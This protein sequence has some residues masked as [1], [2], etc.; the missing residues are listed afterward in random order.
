MDINMRLN[1][2]SPATRGFSLV[3]LSMVIAIIGISLSGALDLATTSTTA[4]MISSTNA[5]LDAVEQALQVFVLNNQR[6]PCPADATASQISA[7]FEGAATVNGCANSNFSSGTVYEGMVPTKTLGLSDQY[8]ADAWNRRFTYV[9]D[10]RFANSASTAIC[11]STTASQMCF[12]NT[13]I[14]QSTDTSSIKINGSSGTQIAANAAYAIISHGPNGSGAWIYSGSATRIAA[15]SDADEKS[16][17]G[18]D[19]GTFDNIFVQKDA[20]TTFDDIARYSTKAN[21][22]E[23]IGGSSNPF[24]GSTCSTASDASSNPTKGPTDPCPLAFVS[25]TCYA[26]AAQVDSLCLAP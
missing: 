3:E 1:S 2:T 24:T 7:G 11:S 17:T 14:P 9:V 22:T 20:T 15:S 18:N 6:L 13:T 26:L 21:I 19:A 4:Q 8:M 12:K 23:S 25:N 16:N 10:A 5:R